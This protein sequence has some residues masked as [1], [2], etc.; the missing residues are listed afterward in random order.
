METAAPQSRPTYW[1]ALTTG[2]LAALLAP[3]QVDV[4]AVEEF[5]NTPDTHVAIGDQVI[6]SIT[7]GTGASQ[8]AGRIYLQFTPD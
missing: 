4:T 7:P 8:G 5:E 3:D 2:D 1:K 6:V